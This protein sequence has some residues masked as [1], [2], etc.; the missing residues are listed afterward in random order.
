MSFT[1]NPKTHVFGF[2]GVA[3]GADCSDQCRA[4]VCRKQAVHTVGGIAL[5]HLVRSATH[6]VHAGSPTTTRW[7][8]HPN[9]PKTHAVD[10]LG[11]HDLGVFTITEITLKIANTVPPTHLIS[12]AANT[13][14]V[15]L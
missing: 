3:P 7:R 5:G 6:A 1:W 2:I 11:N 15:D 8:Q 13:P 12:G 4:V 10:S 14:Y 9:I